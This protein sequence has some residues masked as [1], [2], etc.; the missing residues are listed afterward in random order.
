MIQ[1]ASP[2]SLGSAGITLRTVQLNSRFSRLGYVV[3]ANKSGSTGLFL[4]KPKGEVGNLT[5]S[6]FKYTEVKHR[7]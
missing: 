1:E 5:M 4:I 3:G 7:M 2:R 6:T